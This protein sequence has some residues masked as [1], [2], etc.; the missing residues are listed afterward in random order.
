MPFCGAFVPFSITDKQP[1]LSLSFLRLIVFVFL[2]VAAVSVPKKKRKMKELN[3]KEA[4]GDLLDAFKEV[5]MRAC[6]CMFSIL[7]PPV[8][9]SVPVY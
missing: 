5:C 4:V 2:P 8:S 9:K 1:L 6:F 7:Y 3:K